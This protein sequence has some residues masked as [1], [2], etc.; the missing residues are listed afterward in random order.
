[1]SE[2]FISPE[3]P[4]EG[5]E[6]EILTILIEEAA[7][8]QQRATKSLRFGVV[9]IQPGQQLTNAQRLGLEIGDFMEIVEL[10]AGLGLVDREAITI[11][12]VGKKRQ[13]AK[14]L[15]TSS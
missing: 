3:P 2:K 1:M 13:L 4:P 7:E 6:R 14:F 12:R 8:V 15:Q 9:E 10:A 11:G 5:R